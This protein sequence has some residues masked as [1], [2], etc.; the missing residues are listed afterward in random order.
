MKKIA[1]LLLFFI[2]LGFLGQAQILKNIKVQIAGTLSSLI[3]DEEKNSITNLTL[4]G[5]I[6]ARDVK[7]MRDELINLEILNISLVDVN[8][9]SGTEGTNVWGLNENYPK[10]EMPHYV[11]RIGKCSEIGNGTTVKMASSVQ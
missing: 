4:T 9:Y 10:S 2:N 3:T 5:Y 7:F 8:A 11:T 6:D 1:F